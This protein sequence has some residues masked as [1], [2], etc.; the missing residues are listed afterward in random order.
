MLGGLLVIPVIFCSRHC[1][2]VRRTT[3]TPRSP[4]KTAVFGAAKIFDFRCSEYNSVVS[5]L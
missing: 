2:A 1:R 5:E 3:R 4:T